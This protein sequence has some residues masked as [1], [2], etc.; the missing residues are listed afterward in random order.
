MN[1]IVAI[2]LALQAPAPTINPASVYGLKT[3]T[4]NPAFGFL[5]DRFEVGFP[6][7]TPEDLTMQVMKVGSTEPIVSGGFYTHANNYPNF[8]VLRF[9]PVPTV[10]LPDSGKYMIEFRNKSEKV[11]EFPFEITRKA[12]GDEFNPTY[13]WD[14]KTPVD[15]MGAIY[16]DTSKTDGNVFAMAW[17]APRR[18]GIAENAGATVI[19]NHNGKAV[20][21]AKGLFFQ[22]PQNA[23]RIM[24]LNSTE[25][26]GKFTQTDLRKLNG[27]IELVVKVGTKVIRKFP[28]TIANGQFKL[29]P[30]S[31]TD[32]AP[33][34]GYFVPRYLA[35]S[36]EGYSNFTLCELHWSDNTP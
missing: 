23:R 29:Y 6:P 14:Y 25:K 11:S 28:W 30:K 9:I 16:F 5:P 26:I 7:S 10:D 15:K 18:E 8:H 12:T 31:V 13:F 27:K 35:G 20:A 1:L 21:E 17:F 19:L 36:A 4:A 2:A 24:R 3:Y 32:F 34:T 33:R 22:E